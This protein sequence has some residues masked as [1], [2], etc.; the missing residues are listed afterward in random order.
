MISAK[1]N[2]SN[3]KGTWG[4]EG[5]PATQLEK[6]SLYYSAEWFVIGG[7]KGLYKQNNCAIL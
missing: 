7:K 5:L 6:I 4:V 1:W 3:T 2:P